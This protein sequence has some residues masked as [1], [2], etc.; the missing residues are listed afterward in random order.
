MAKQSGEKKLSAVEYQQQLDAGKRPKKDKKYPFRTLR[1]ANAYADTL[2]KNRGTA[3][4]PDEVLSGDIAAV[5]ESKNISSSV[6]SQEVRSLV[7]RIIGKETPANIDSLT[8]G[9]K[10]L[11]YTKIRSLPR[12]SRPTNLIDFKSPKAAQPVAPEAPLALPAPATAPEVAVIQ[13]AL[14]KAMDQAGLSDVKANINHGL[15]TVLKDNDGNLVFG[16]RRRRSGDESV[17]SFGGP[18]SPIVVDS[19]ADGEAFYSDA[20]GQIFFGLDRLPE[21]LSTEQKVEAILDILSHEQVHAL[22]ALDL[23]IDSEWTLLRKT[24]KQRA[25]SDGQTYFEWAQ[26]NYPELNEVG[27][28]EESIAELVRDY[29]GGRGAFSGKNKL[30]GKPKK[31]VAKNG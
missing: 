23:F 9:E 25:K 2:N 4:V 3:A 17:E 28:I 10:K 1:G 7:G 30:S 29:R 21:G 31:S 6:E 14:D 27:Q 8:E 16:I 18:G 22:R 26:Q 5:L 15:S 19:T 24:A 12:F 13:E 11:A 20:T